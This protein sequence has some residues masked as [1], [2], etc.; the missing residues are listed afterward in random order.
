MYDGIDAMKIIFLQHELKDVQMLISSTCN[1]GSAYFK[2][3]IPV[4]D[5]STDSMAAR[6]KGQEQE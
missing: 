2:H 6:G 3:A 1:E 4:I 5:A